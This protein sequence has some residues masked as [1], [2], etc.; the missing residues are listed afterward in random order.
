[1]QIE[2]LVQLI[3]AL[4]GRSVAVT[5]LSGGITNQNFRVDVDGESYVVRVA[6]ELTD[7]LGIDRSVE[8]AC[9]LAAAGCGL[10]PEVV[11]F[12]PEH[13]A[14]V[15]RFVSGQMLT[16]EDVRNP[17]GMRR[18]VAALRRYHESGSGAG[19]FSPFATVRSYFDLAKAHNVE[20]PGTLRVAMGLLDRVEEA[21][22]TAEP[23]FPCHNDLLPSN[24]VDDGRS[25]WIID[26]E[27]AGM[28]DRFFDLGNLAVNNS[29][30]ERHERALLEM[31][32][33]EVREEHV[34]RLRLM[35]LAS[36]MR[37]SMWGFLQS[38]ISRL[39]F[40]FSAYAL[41]HLQRFL[42]AAEENG[43]L[44]REDHDWHG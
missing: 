30:E 31:Y 32:F 29:F 24:L 18:I 43:E 16:P 37:E 4:A 10:G 13:G 17:A 9:A 3:P 38:G 26:W 1:V 44:T 20:F 23:A 35:R 21:T 14:L 12:L 8:Y 7:L 39:D 33:G 41:D 42:A 34:R 6:G 25:L 11:D 36:D 15:T 19:R 5:R 28:G 22:K 27:Y 2:A 40:D